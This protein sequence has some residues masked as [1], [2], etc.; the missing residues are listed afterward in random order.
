M[1]GGTT[2]GSMMEIVVSIESDPS[3]KR[4]ILR[5]LTALLPEWFG[6]AESNLHY[7]KQ[8][9]VLTGYVARVDGEVRGMLLLKAHN[10][11]SIEIYWLGVNPD[12]HRAGIGHALVETTC[13]AAQADGVKF[14]FVSTLHPSE[15]YEPYQR[16]RQFYAA[17]GFRYVLEEQIPR[18]G[19]PLAYYMRQLI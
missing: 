14:V 13:K 15:A 18:E 19:N 11:D 1:G 8:A 12:C 16:T 5:N 6:Q 4:G 17:M 7:A 3:R 10:R 2:S 9:E